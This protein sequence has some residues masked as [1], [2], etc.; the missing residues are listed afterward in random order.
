MSVRNIIEIDRE[1]CNGCGNCVIA[2]A[3]GALAI[4]DGV[5]TLVKDSYCD[6]LGACLGDCPTDALKI[7]RKEVDDFDEEA[8]EKHLA[9]RKQAKF[10]CPSQ[11]AKSWTQSQDNKAN[12]NR[13]ESALTHWPVKLELISPQAPVLQNSDLLIAAD[14]VPF[15]YSNLHADFLAGKTLLIGCPKLIND[16]NRYLEKLTAIFKIA[17]LKSVTVLHMEVPCCF[18]LVRLVQ[19]AVSSANAG[20]PV[21][22][23]VI[24]IR[25]EKKDLS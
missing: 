7:T 11:Q 24:S 4:V 15:A 13:S 9:Q 20:F 21:E 17:N 18:G 19:Q 8:V 6:G 1:K 16:T 10:Q 14:C 22:E 5:A 2:C 3:E 25:G 23:I 12:A